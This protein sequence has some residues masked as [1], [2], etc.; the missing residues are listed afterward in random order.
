[1]VDKRIT[2][3]SKAAHPL[4]EKVLASKP[5]IQVNNRL[6]EINADR[7]Y[8]HGTPPPFTSYTPVL[9]G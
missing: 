5:P 8:F 7:V 9:C 3:C 2:D 1:M 6:A 4:V